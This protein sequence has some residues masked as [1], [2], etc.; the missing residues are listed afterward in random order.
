MRG[1]GARAF[2]YETLTALNFEIYETFHSE[3]HKYIQIL[4]KVKYSTFISCV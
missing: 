1:V 2:I 3:I 4:L